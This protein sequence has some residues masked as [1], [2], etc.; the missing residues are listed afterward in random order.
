MMKPHHR[1][2]HH[3]HRHGPFG[4]GGRGGRQRRGNVRAAVLSLLA[5]RPMHGYEIIQEI[6]RR[7]GGVW[8]PSP[9]SVY[10]T[11]QML[12]DEGFISSVEEGG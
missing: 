1:D 11:L 3:R 4:G 2:H 12:A 6:A 7:T 5:E 9:G 10:P 8:S